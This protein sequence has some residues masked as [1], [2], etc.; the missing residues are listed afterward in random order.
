MEFIVTVSNL[1]NLEKIKKTG[2][3]GIL[4]GSLF[5]SRFNFEYKEMV[6]SVFKAQD[7]GLKVFISVDGFVFG[8]DESLLYDYLNQLK[9]MNVDGI[10]FSDL[11]VLEISKNLNMQELLSYDGGPM[12]TNSLDAGYYIENGINSV[13][14][15]RELNLEEIKKICEANKGF[16]D[17]QIFGHIRLSITRRKFLSNYFK[18]INSDYE[19]INKETLSLEEEQRSYRLPIVENK[20]GTI[21]YSDYIFEMY[22]ELVDLI[23]YLNRGI[24]DD[25]FIDFDVIN[26]VCIGLRR[27]T[28]ENA[29]FLFTE[30]KIR[31]PL[32]NLSKGYLYETLNLKKDGED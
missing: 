21:I 4:M 26:E 19:Y 31:Y 1:D 24:I 16:I 2:I 6:D 18:E 20:E 17:L 12:M 13:V 10:Y 28:K 5:S 25:R 14:L 11:A 27:V 9:N 30:L 7:L 29:K 22:E 8:D 3:D 15:A 32:V 23:P